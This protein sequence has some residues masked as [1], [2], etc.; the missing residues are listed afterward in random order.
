[1]REDLRARACFAGKD[2]VAREKQRGFSGVKMGFF[3]GGRG[4]LRRGKKV[5]EGLEMLKMKRQGNFFRF[6]AV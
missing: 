6:G 2:G 1:M 4:F 3:K 5:R